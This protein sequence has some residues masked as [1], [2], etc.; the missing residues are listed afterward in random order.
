[1]QPTELMS[2]F[3]LTQENLNDF[4][5]RYEGICAGKPFMSKSQFMD[6]WLG[7]EKPVDKDN[8]EFGSRIW[9]A[10]DV[11]RNGKMDYD[12]WCLYCAIQEHGTMRHKLTAAFVLCDGTKDGLLTEKEVAD[13]FNR[14][15]CIEARRLLVLG[16]RKDLCKWVKKPGF[17]EQVEINTKTKKI[18]KLADKNKDGKVSLEEFLGAAEE[19]PS[20]FED[21]VKKIQPPRDAEDE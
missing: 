7:D 15:F 9:A 5:S 19:D 3:G 18:I 11:D 14:A 12:E 1:M 6:Y 2:E 17:Q 4:K 21:L 10:F 8:K 20:L 16:G 13:I